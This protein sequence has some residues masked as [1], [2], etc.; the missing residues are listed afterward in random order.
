MFS[1]I[2]EEVGTVA[3]LEPAGG[4]TT[5]VVR[6]RTVLEGTR[7]GDSISVNGACLTV[8]SLTEDA[9]AVNL[10]PVT[11]R[12]TNL[13][14]LRPGSAVNLERSVA[15]GGRIGG[16]YV[17]GH[18]DGT[19][20]VVSL[21]PEGQSVIVRLIAPREIRHYIVQRGFIAVDGTSLTVMEVWPD[22][23]TVSLVQHTQAHTTLAHQRPGYRAN[24]EVDVIAKY[25]E[26][27]I[28][29]REQPKPLD[30][31]ALRRA[32]YA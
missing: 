28:T 9:F 23:F 7:I 13:G 6:C 14:D 15:V 10:Q 25:V 16:H 8:T 20:E 29:E 24:L 17:Q 22:G 1:G 19:G 18:V 27:L 2:I 26:R 4:D 32:G 11:M 5:L 3:A 31:D 12:L 30:W 21:T